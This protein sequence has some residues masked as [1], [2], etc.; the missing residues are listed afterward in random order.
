M[1]SDSQQFLNSDVH[2]AI[3]KILEVNPRSISDSTV[4][5]FILREMKR[6]YRKCDIASAIMAI[7]D[8]NQFSVISTTYCRTCTTHGINDKYA[9]VLLKNKRYQ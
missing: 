9:Q 8:R 7:W 4:S 6:T 2:M 3:S 5:S 1:Q